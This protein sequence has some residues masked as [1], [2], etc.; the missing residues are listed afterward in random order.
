MSMESRV[1][2]ITGAKGGLGSF[3]T[4]AFLAAGA[5]VIGT[6]RSIKQSDFPNPRFNA[7]AVDFSDVA[8]VN[9]AVSEIVSRFGKIDVLAHIMGGFAAGT[10]AETDDKTW[11]QM[12]D[13]NLTSAFHAMRAV[14]PTM[15]KAKYGR[16]VTVGSLAATEAHAGIGSY[17]ASKMAMASLTQAVALENSD[18]NITANV[19]LP[20]TM[21]TPANRASMPGADFSKWVRPD[22]V[23]SVILTLADESSKLITGTLVPI[24]GH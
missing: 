18:A 4:E 21:D 3:V 7:M 16:I 23:A 19:V 17:V 1:V 14:L 12:L 8:A 13:L 9:A 15:R 11:S 10:V 5:T 20:G 6:S 24:Q 2:L 22:D